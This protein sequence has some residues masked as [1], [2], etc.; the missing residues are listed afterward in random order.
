MLIAAWFSVFEMIGGCVRRYLRALILGVLCFELAA[1]QS[2]PLGM[3]EEEW[4]G[5]TPAQQYEA[6]T[7]Q[8]ELDEQ[9]RA[10]RAAATAAENTLKA[11]EAA[12][13]QERIDKLRQNAAYGDEIQCLIQNAL[14]DFRPGWRSALDVGFSLVR[15]EARS[16]DLIDKERGIRRPLWV[17]YSTDGMQ[18]TLCRYDPAERGYN[19]PND[20]QR[21]IGTTGD[22]QRGIN[23]SIE[24]PEI[25]RGG[26]RCQLAPGKG[27]PSTIILRRE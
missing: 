14:V 3:T 4:A 7:K 26:L 17:Q 11:E 6:R 24:L 12:R 16:V 10:R 15:S 27:M 23:K 1:C 9:A 20:C 8:A 19:R 21:F 18:V 13:R 25:L 22:F 5:L 2:F